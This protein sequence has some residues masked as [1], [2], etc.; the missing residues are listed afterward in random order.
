MK[1]RSQYFQLSGGSS[2]GGVVGGIWS[3]K[4]KTSKQ[5]SATSWLSQWEGEARKNLFL[6]FFFGFISRHFMSSPR[7]PQRLARASAVWFLHRCRRVLL[8]FFWCFF[9][10]SFKGI[11]HFCCY[12]FFFLAV[13]FLVWICLEKSALASVFAFCKTNVKKKRE[14]KISIRH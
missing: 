14:H 2:E 6:F 13:F 7:F 9:P 3:I 12:I 10:P 5:T 11:F 4:T 8:V 1:G